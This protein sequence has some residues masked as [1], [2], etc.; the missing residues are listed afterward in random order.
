M[1]LL[2]PCMQCFQ[3]F[4]R[5]TEELSH[6]GFRDD[7]RYEVKC[8]FGH[9]TITLLQQQ[10]FEILFD[11]GA[12]AILDGYYREAISSFTSSLERFYEFSLR[13]F[14][15]KESKSDGL[16]QDC[17]KKVA[18]QS[19]RQ[20]GAFI[21]LWASHFGKPPELLSN[22]QT[23]FRNDVVH[24]GKIP[25]RE[26]AVKYGNAVLK[27]LQ[28]M[29]AIIKGR[30]SEEVMRVTFYHL[31]GARSDSDIGKNLSTMGISTLVSLTYEGDGS[32]NKV[33]ED[34]L[35]H[36]VHWRKITSFQGD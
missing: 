26:E 33:L 28:S 17:W 8:S 12:Y 9:E 2:I 14:L 11:I 30:Y 35:G 25:T 36:L 20:L 1:K 27:L 19:E 34:Y 7:G 18:P 6:V 31:N 15:E 32:P 23:S 4:G 22:A 21:F 24:K 16:F 29:I 5:P 13:V 10:K 3:E